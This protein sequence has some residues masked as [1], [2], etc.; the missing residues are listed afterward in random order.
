MDIFSKPQAGKICCPAGSRRS[1]STGAMTI[2]L[3]LF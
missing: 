3:L 1:S 2:F